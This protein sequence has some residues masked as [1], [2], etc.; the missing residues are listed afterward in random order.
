MTQQ[1]YDDKFEY[2]NEED[3]D[4]LKDDNEEYY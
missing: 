2:E 3:D 1:K 4:F